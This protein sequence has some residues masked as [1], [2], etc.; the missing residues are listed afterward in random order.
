MSRLLW[1]RRPL[2]QDAAAVARLVRASGFFNPAE[3]AVARELVGERLAKGLA[4]G[5]RFW[6]AQQ[7]ESLAGYACYGP[8]AGA[9]GSWDLYWIVVDRAL[10]G[11]GLGGRILDRVASSAAAA[12]CRR[13]Y[14]DTSSRPQYG[15]TRAFYQARGFMEQARLPAFYAPGEDKVIYCLQTARLG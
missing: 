9:E 2:A 3:V 7:G 11:R 1:R 6:F 5:Y 10:R 14:A 8:I 13:L 15:P 4:S 12:G